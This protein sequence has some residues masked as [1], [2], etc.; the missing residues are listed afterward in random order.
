MKQITNWDIFIESLLSLIKISLLLKFIGALGFIKGIIF[1]AIALKIKKSLLNWYLA[2]EQ[3]RNNDKI[4]ISSKV[5]K[6][7]NLIGIVFLDDFDQ[8]KI[9]NFIIEKAIKKIKAFRSRI[10]YKY[11]NYYWQE[12]SFE[13]SLKRITFINDSAQFKAKESVLEF[14]NKEIS[15]YLDLLNE[16]PYKIYLIPY[17]DPKDKKGAFVMKVDHVMADGLSA[18]SLL[19]GIADNYSPAVFPSVMHQKK[20]PFLKKVNTYIPFLSYNIIEFIFRT[21]YDSVFFPYYAPYIFYKLL[22]KNFGN[23]PF[24]SLKEPLATQVCHFKASKEFDLRL[25]NQIRRHEKLM[26]SFNELIMSALSISIKKICEKDFK[27]YKHLKQ[28]MSVIPIGMKGIPET[29]NHI[30]I[31]NSTNAVY[32]ELS[33]IK[34]LALEK[35]SIREDFSKHLKDPAISATMMNI[36]NL[37]LEFFPLE[38]IHYLGNIFFKNVDFLT[39]NVP[40]PRETIYWDGCK[41]TDIIALLSSSRIKTAIPII[42]YVDTFKFFVVTDEN[43][44]LDRDEFIKVMEQ[45]LEEIADSYVK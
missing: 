33:L 24:K 25:F 43:C 28:V 30:E 45:T 36:S 41:V 18:V 11:F 23:T 35:G 37:T 38:I 6:M 8:E 40:G 44:K 29:E 31:N 9:K 21:I 19:C 26:I 10:V 16:A 20:I 27:Q 4:F 12:I 42:S 3:I 5:S 2:M 22:T 32:N 34:N 1:F 14:A 15:N 39:T 13:E 7:F 17:G